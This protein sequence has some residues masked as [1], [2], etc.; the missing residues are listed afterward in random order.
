MSDYTVAAGHPASLS[1]QAE[2]AAD[3][4]AGMLLMVD[5]T[6]AVLPAGAATS[7]YVGVAGNNATTSPDPIF[8]G[9]VTVL[10]GTG[11]IHETPVPAPV[12]I[13][14]FVVCGANGIVV[15][16]ATP[17]AGTVGVVVGAVVDAAGDNWC[18]WL[19]YR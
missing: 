18:R 10:C 6:G 7:P 1:Y 11:V 9:Q 5:G 17:A 4:T 14:E 12:T 2:A 13:G 19:A 8:G 15:G 3:I 16:A